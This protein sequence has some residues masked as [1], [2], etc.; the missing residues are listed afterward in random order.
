[1]RGGGRFAA[2]TASREGALAA[3]EGDLLLHNN[4]CARFLPINQ[5]SVDAT[6]VGGGYDDVHS[7]AQS[8]TRPECAFCESWS[9]FQASAKSTMGRQK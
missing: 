8:S 7:T 6:E 1:M 2:T 4:V 9:F 5:L 3:D